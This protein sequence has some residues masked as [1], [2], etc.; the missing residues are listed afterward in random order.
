MSER[1]SIRDLAKIAGVSRTTV[2]LALRDSHRISPAVRKHVQELAAKHH[3]Q[4]HPMV[5]A[6]M[7]QIRS[8]KRVHGE[9]TIAFITSESTPEEWRTRQSVLDLWEGASSEAT[10]FGFHLERFWAG[11]GAR[12]SKSLANMLYHRG[13]RGLLF[14][15]MLWPHPVLSMPWEKFVQLACTAST[16]VRELPVV[17]SNQIRGARLL[18]GHVAELGAKSIG[19]VISEEDDLRIERRWSLGVHAFGLEKRNVKTELLLLPNYDEFDSFARWFKRARPDVLVCLRHTTVGSFLE[20]LDCKPG[21]DLA[22]ASLDVSSETL[23]KIAGFYQDPFY[24]GRKA[25]QYI[26][27][28]IYDQTLGL[29]DHPESIVVDGRLVDGDSLNPLKNGGATKA[30]SK[31]KRKRAIAAGH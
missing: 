23:G 6:L 25:I 7:Q 4:S 27:K 24:L 18:L 17:R 19:V 3:Y 26:S 2:S 15:P 20:K 8:K 21:V 12:N 5:A 29:P 16:G 31:P 14:A 1:I 11:P 28:S 30:K 13:I 22:F 10:R 9:E